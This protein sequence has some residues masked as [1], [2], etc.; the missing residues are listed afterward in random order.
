[1]EL[2]HST[3]QDELGRLILRLAKTIIKNRNHHLGALGLTA[4]Q[5]DSLQFFLTH[6]STTATDLKNY[7]GITHQTARG[8]VGRLADKGLVE[9][10][11]S[12]A[13]ARCQIVLPTENGIQM[14]SRMRRNRERT[15]EA[16]LTGMSQEEQ[17]LFFRL[18]QQA[19]QQA[20]HDWAAPNQQENSGF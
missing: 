13:D 18:L 1:M 11:R 10:R 19:L 8:L 14:G 4:G 7:L 3:A 20:E 6:E 15:G 16:L 5:A 12:P 2:E 17:A 9:L